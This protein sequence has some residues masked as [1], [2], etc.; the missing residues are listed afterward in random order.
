MTFDSAIRDLVAR[1]VKNEVARVLKAEP[2]DLLTSRFAARAAG[3]SVA[4]IR[5]WVRD[6]RLEAYRTGHTLRIRRDALDKLLK[7]KRA[8]NDATPEQLAKAQFG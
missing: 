8:D 3:V 1:L 2:D 6:G 7:G 4:T 5:R